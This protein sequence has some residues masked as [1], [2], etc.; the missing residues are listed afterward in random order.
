MLDIHFPSELLRLVNEGHLD[1]EEIR[2]AILDRLPDEVLYAI[3]EQEEACAGPET[4][5]DDEDDLLPRTLRPM[6]EQFPPMDDASYDRLVA[7]FCDFGKRAF[8]INVDEESATEELTTCVSDTSDPISMTPD[9]DYIMDEVDAT[10]TS[11]SDDVLYKRFYNRCHAKLDLTDEPDIGFYQAS[12]PKWEFDDLDNLTDI[13][14]MDFDD[15][16]IF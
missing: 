5:V 1:R 16:P 14:T 12:D 7:N 4:P 13:E 9:I 6:E 8:G 15:F 10:T 2:A 11:S 3:L